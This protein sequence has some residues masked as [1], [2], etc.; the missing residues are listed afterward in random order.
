MAACLGMLF[1]GI[2]LITLGSVVPG[3]KEKYHLDEI[4]AGTLFSIMP[5][6]ILVGSLLFGPCCD[7]YGYKILLT[8]CCFFMFAG[9]EG[10]AFAPSQS[11]LK[12]CVFLFGIG[13]G[14]VNGATNALVSDI[15]EKDKGANL[16]LLGVSFGLGALGMPFILGLLENKFNYEVI[17][18]AVGVATFI[19]GIFYLLIKFPLPKQ[20]SGFPL[21]HSVGLIK[22]ALLILI[23]FFLFCQSSFEAII[24][25]WTT[26]YLTKQLSILPGKALYALSLFVV[27]MTVMRLLLGS[28]FRNTSVK[29]IW[30]GSFSMILIGL[31][32]LAIGKSFNASVTG[33]IILGAGLAGGFPIMLG[34]VGNSYRELSGTAFSLVLVIALAGNIIINYCMGIIAQKYGIQHLITVAFAELF[35]MIVLCIFI[36]KKLNKNQ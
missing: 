10:I 26:T 5:F 14:A 6:G 2:S 11:V 24:N 21:A 29:R 27:G 15:S 23:A 25:N 16:S 12:I 34:F 7:K 1:F 3:L 35:I 9:F 17:V 8:V 30:L 22:D 13:G 4:S 18:S 33:L 32:F 31:L 19:V 28:I 20:S 36:L